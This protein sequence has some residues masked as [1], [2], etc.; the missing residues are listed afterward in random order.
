MQRGVGGPDFDY[1]YQL[2][3]T[4][5]TVLDGV[6]T[7]LQ[8]A[9]LTA[10]A[11][12]SRTALD[13]ATARLMKNP[14]AMAQFMRSDPDPV[15]LSLMAGPR[16]MANLAGV[17]V[18]G[19]E[20]PTFLEKAAARAASRHLVIA[21]FDPKAASADQSRW[22]AGRQ[23]LVQGFSGHGV[24]RVLETYGNAVRSIAK[25]RSDRKGYE[26]ESWQPVGVMSG[27]PAVR[28]SKPYSPPVDRARLVLEQDGHYDRSTVAAWKAVPAARLRQTVSQVHEA[29]GR[30]RGTVVHGVGRAGR[31]A[32]DAVGSVRDSTAAAVAGARDRAAATAGAVRDRAAGTAAAI[33]ER[34]AAAAAAVR[35]RT[36]AAVGA[37][38]DRA[39]G[40]VGGVR[41]R[42]AAAVAGV[43]ERRARAATYRQ[44][45][46]ERRAQQKARYAEKHA[47]KKLVKKFFTDVSG[48]GRVKQLIN[49]ARFGRP[50]AEK[51]FRRQFVKAMQRGQ[52]ETQEFLRNVAKSPQH[53]AL[54][55]SAGL[56][57]LTVMSV[58]G[59]SGGSVHTKQREMSQV[60]N[61][62]VPGDLS[63]NSYLVGGGSKTSAGYDGRVDQLILDLAKQE[64]ADAERAGKEGGPAVRSTKMR[65]DPAYR[66]A[67]R[68]C[69]AESLELRADGPEIEKIERLWEDRRKLAAA[70]ARGGGERNPYVSEAEAQREADA[71]QEASKRRLDEFKSETKGLDA[72]VAKAR[73]DHRNHRSQEPCTDQSWVLEEEKARRVE[74]ERVVKQ[75]KWDK[76]FDGHFAD[77]LQR[78]TGADK[79]QIPAKPESRPAQPAAAKTEPRPAQP[80]AA[81]SEP[82][83][84]QP[85]AA[86]TEPRPAQPAAAK[87]EP[88]PAQPAA[89]KSEPRPAQPAAATSEPRPAQPVAAKTEPRPA[90]PA[91]AKTEPRLA[92]AKARPGAVP[93]RE[94]VR[95]DRAAAGGKPAR[96][97]GA[98]PSAPKVDPRVQW[99]LGQREMSNPPPQAVASAAAG[100]AKVKTVAA[101][102]RV[103]AGS[104][105]GKGD[106]RRSG[107]GRVAGTAASAVPGSSR[108]Q[109]SDLEK[110]LAKGRA[111]G[112]S[113]GGSRSGGGKPSSDRELYLRPPQ[114]AGGSPGGGSSSGQGKTSQKRELYLRPGGGQAPH[115]SPGGAARASLELKPAGVGLGKSAPAR[116]PQ[117]PSERA[118]REARSRTPARRQ[119]ASRV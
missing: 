23:V 98:V 118:A 24:S 59:G 37:V 14:R 29:V 38:R 32:A 39:A 40:A 21:K 55:K 63:P 57:S 12:K 67:R 101:D 86:K 2:E 27:L 56:D 94:Q 88:R 80:A 90:Q 6:K 99:A 10:A 72:D 30:A 110:L 4:R 48:G 46:R 91:A 13:A 36:A 18:G 109:A 82:R 108:R 89:A 25:P 65:E 15:L 68:E 54:A 79:A 52:A 83:P 66:Q 34:T 3:E 16:A 51:T 58:M 35:G 84:A 61:N 42:A 77:S 103:A 47:H 49:K 22:A 11:S 60:L 76:Y 53:R 116:A 19:K 31:S 70:E 100:G 75:E 115:G 78:G 105:N 64:K 74:Q 106:G 33:R 43:Q 81:K 7:A 73:S 111:A 1:Q 92:V 107:A 17:D 69:I 20:P 102:R 45:I 44:V 87:T 95:S 41:D 119:S 85:V 97:A 113:P 5:T 104:S 28:G 50:M 71:H 112:S 62:V 9:K 117:R 114:N 93:V 96:S 8:A 26:R